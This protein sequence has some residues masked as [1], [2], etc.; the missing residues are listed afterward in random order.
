[1]VKLSEERFAPTRDLRTFAV[2]SVVRSVSLFFFD[3]LSLKNSSRIVMAG[4]LC[5]QRF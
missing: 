1:M 4:F 3:L 5:R 2:L